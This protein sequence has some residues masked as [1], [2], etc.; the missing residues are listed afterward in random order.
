[1]KKILP[2]VFALVVCASVIFTV[3]CS[4]GSSDSSGLSNS[5][6]S[7]PI[8]GTWES[9]KRDFIYI[10]K[11]DYT[12]EIK[13]SSGQSYTFEWSITGNTLKV[14]SEGYWMTYQYTIEADRLTLNGQGVSDTMVFQRAS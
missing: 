9:V 7:N 6:D 8:I 13:A 12:V 5:S 3:A 1:M 2:A 10:F 14:G 4:S 11:S